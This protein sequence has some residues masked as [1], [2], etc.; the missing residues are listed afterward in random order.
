MR[1]K[2]QKIEPILIDSN[3][4]SRF[5]VDQGFVTIVLDVVVNPFFYTSKGINS[6]SA[7]IS[8]ENLDSS[9]ERIKKARSISQISAA[10]IELNQKFSSFRKGIIASKKIDLTTLISNEE[11]NS[12]TF[13]HKFLA[14]PG[15]YPSLKIGTY[16]VENTGIGEGEITTTK[17]EEFLN[18]GISP[19]SIIAD[20]PIKLPDGFSRSFNRL[21]KKIEDNLS[22]KQ[23]ISKRFFKSLNKEVQYDICEIKTPFT[24]TSLEIPIKLSDAILGKQLFVYVGSSIG[25]SKKL[26]INQKLG[27]IIS[28]VF[29][30]PVENDDEL[31]KEQIGNSN[32]PQRLDGLGFPILSGK[33]L[34]DSSF[35]TLQNKSQTFTS[36]VKRGLPQKGFSEKISPELIQKTP[37]GSRQIIRTKASP[38]FISQLVGKQ[39]KIGM[40]SKTIVIPFYVTPINDGFASIAISEIPSDIVSIQIQRKEQSRGSDYQ[41]IDQ[42]ILKS[43]AQSKSFVDKTVVHSR[44]YSYRLSCFDKRGNIVFTS[45]TV[46]YTHI[47]NEISSFND[48]GLIFEIQSTNIENKSA[49]PTVNFTFNIQL[50]ERGIT[51]LGEFLTNAGVDKSVIQGVISDPRNYGNVISYN[52]LRQNLTTS[53][54]ENL[55]TY[56]ATTF[57]DDSSFNS[58][59][60]VTPLSIETDY[61]YVFKPSIRPAGAITN[62]QI[63]QRR[64]PKTGKSYT[65]N[66][67]KFQSRKDSLNLPSEEEMS[68]KPSEKIFSS[69]EFLT[70]K[71]VSVTVKS[72]K[73]APSI[74]SPQVSKNLLGA[75]SIKWKSSSS[76]GEIDH[77]QIYA[78]LD[79]V[80]SYL[81]AAHALDDNHE[82][83]DYSLYDRVGELTYKIVPVLSDFTVSNVFE[84]VTITKNTSLSRTMEKLLANQ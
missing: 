25:S 53:E 78:I 33:K 62:E 69:I 14:I 27:E 19:D 34:G 70:S 16:T 74:F 3:S 39:S 81:G 41:N 82:Y 26:R 67:Y 20:F 66:S 35:F 45:N 61:R 83:E 64:D 65:F 80:Q 51:S 42:P 54:I 21:S 22:K 11:K 31:R 43:E 8:T 48:D 18:S 10:E 13:T 76:P 40:E 57:S 29:N 32:L 38:T 59:L 71:E 17:I 73:S 6:I 58:S 75:N 72:T 37:T 60:G 68:K 28:S 23:K 44:N 1:S 4:L 15:S 47:S 55:G 52:I 63:T 7:I 30:I 12:R 50:T 79:G 77:F 49:F 84:T 2:I 9:Q 5:V 56:S 46:D 24:M 36:P